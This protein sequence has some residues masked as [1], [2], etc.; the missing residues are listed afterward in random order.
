[1]Q[2]AEQCS[3]SVNVP[4]SEKIPVSSARHWTAGAAGMVSVRG[5]EI[6]S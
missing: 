1:M 3:G 6:K 4:S 5:K 2:L